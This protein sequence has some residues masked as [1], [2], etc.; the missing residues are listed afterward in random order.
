MEQKYYVPNTNI[1]GTCDELLRNSYR[2]ESDFS[3]IDLE[4]IIEIAERESKDS[5]IQKFL[6]ESRRE[7]R[8]GKLNLGQVKIDMYQNTATEPLSYG[9]ANVEIWRDGENVIVHIQ[10]VDDD[11]SYSASCS[12]SLQKFLNIPD[13]KLEIVLGGIL[14]YNTVRD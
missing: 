9:D 8:K 6:L 7:I 1:N 4:L 3:D 12:Y 14:Y 5:T 10:G 2:Y 13:G 11:G